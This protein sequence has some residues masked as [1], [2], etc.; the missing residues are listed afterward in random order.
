MASEQFSL[1]ISKD[2]KSRLEELSKAT[3]RTKSCLAID[4]IEKYLETEAWHGD[5]LSLGEVKK[6]WDID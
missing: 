2:T 1:R 3:G 4:A 5:V 6:I